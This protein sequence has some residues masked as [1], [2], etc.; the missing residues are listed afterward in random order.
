[1][2]TLHHPIDRLWL[3]SKEFNYVVGNVCRQSI[4]LKRI[5]SQNWRINNN[6][7]TSLLGALTYW[8]I[9][10]YSICNFAL[11]FFFLP[12][13]TT[14]EHIDKLMWL[15]YVLEEMININ[16]KIH[17]F[18]SSLTLFTFYVNK[19]ILYICENVTAV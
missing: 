5:Y 16:R 3:Y 15:S 7:S 12:K 8:Y 6:C 14:V 13:N 11:G 1:M 2:P 19:D 17:I 4:Q 18:F 10:P 9:W